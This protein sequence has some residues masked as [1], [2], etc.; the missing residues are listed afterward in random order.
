M[1][2]G[3]ERRKESGA[4]KRG[5]R[6]RRNVGLAFETKAGINRGRERERGRHNAASNPVASLTNAQL[7]ISH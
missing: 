5:N 3:E 7:L 4:K 1:K 2:D 6:G